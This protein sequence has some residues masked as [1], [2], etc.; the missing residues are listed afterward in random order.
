[1]TDSKAKSDQAKYPHLKVI[2]GFGFCPLYVSFFFA[3]I[4]FLT[5]T[6]FGERDEKS[7]FEYSL[8]SLRFIFVATGFGM[9]FFVPAFILS[10]FYSFIKVEKTTVGVLFVSM[11]GG[12][13]AHLWSYAAFFPKSADLFPG[14][15]IPSSGF[16]LGFLSSLFAGLVFLPKRTSSL[17]QLSSS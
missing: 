13:G 11:M 2:V 14:V 9:Y 16:L 15:F 1:M 6:F 5:F 4:A 17:P 10:I 7:W 3:V 12:L 8:S